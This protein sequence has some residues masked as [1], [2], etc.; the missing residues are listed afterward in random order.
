MLTQ[1]CSTLKSGYGPLVRNLPLNLARELQSPMQRVPTAT[2]KN[3]E[4]AKK[5]YGKSAEQLRT[6]PGSIRSHDFAHPVDKASAGGM[7]LEE[8]GHMVIPES[9]PS[10]DSASE[11][12]VKEGRKVGD[13]AF[14]HPAAH[15][16]VSLCTTGFTAQLMARYQLKPIWIP[17]D[18]LGIGEAEAEHIRSLGI[19]CSTDGAT[20]NA[21]GHVDISRP[22]PEVPLDDFKKIV[23]TAEDTTDT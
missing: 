11:T 20:M 13:H 14:D 1:L 6:A 12:A 7:A 19:E 9:D 3:D 8:N 10:P 18:L 23:D 4:L 21:S 16:P 17:A 22:P 15:E 2:E 5:L